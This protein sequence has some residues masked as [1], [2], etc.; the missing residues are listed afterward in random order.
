MMRPKF[1]WLHASLLG[2]AL[3]VGCQ[4]THRQSARSSYRPSTPVT[5]LPQY[6]EGVT[7]VAPAQPQTAL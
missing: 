4:N 6:Q 5:M 7:Y 1:R 3:I 2:F